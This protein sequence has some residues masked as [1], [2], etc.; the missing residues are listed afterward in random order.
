[1]ARIRV[2]ARQ[3]G[4]RHYFIHLSNRI[5]IITQTLLK[6]GKGGRKAR[7]KAGYFG[8]P[9]RDSAMVFTN[10]IRG[11]FPK[12]RIEV[13]SAQRLDSPIE[14]KVAGNFVEQL[15]WELVRQSPST[16]QRIARHLELVRSMPSIEPDAPSHRYRAPQLNRGSG[17]KTM[18]TSGGLAIGIE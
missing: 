15:A 12:A 2:R 9:D 3:L 4:D 18:V 16:G 5:A 6:P 13:R 14:V 1:M 11:R 8:F 10:N 7:V 17:R